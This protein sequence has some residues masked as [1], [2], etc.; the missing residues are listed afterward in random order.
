MISKFGDYYDHIKDVLVIIG[1]FIVLAY[2]HSDRM[3]SFGGVIIIYVALMIVAG[4]VLKCQ[5][6]YY[7]KK[8]DSE[9]LEIFGRLFMH[10]ET[11][12]EAESC[13]KRL[14]FFGTG[15]LTLGL[16]VMVLLLELGYI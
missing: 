16:I 5:E 8:Q 14:R 7:G 3:C 12:A 9:S 1:I 15:T 13:L 10:V 2:R 4:Q 11:K 6:V